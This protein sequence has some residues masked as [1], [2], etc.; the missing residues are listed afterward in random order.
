M[1]R[2]AVIMLGGGVAWALHLLG[3][4]AIV[5]LACAG[6]FRGAQPALI[7]LTVLAGAAAIASGALGLSVSGRGDAASG[8]TRFVEHAGVALSALFTFLIVLGGFV[9]AMAPMC[10]V[11]P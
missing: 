10:A 11:S 4:Y 8:A 2:L 9:P 3:S 1:T 7:A 5:A 6:G